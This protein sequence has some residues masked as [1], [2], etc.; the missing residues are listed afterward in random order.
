MLI[1][2]KLRCY[3][4]EFQCLKTVPLTLSIFHK[5]INHLR[6]KWISLN[7]SWKNQHRITLHWKSDLNCRL[8]TNMKRRGQYESI[9]LIAWT[10]QDHHLDTKIVGQCI[11]FSWSHWKMSKWQRPCNALYN[12][13]LQGSNIINNKC[14]KRFI[15][16]FHS[17]IL[18][19]R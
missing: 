14:S 15:P 2:T 18:D 6:Q 7:A 1:D 5:S 3:Y 17:T 8:M 10:K 4:Y 16:Q 13:Y 12:A 11:G 9:E 19:L